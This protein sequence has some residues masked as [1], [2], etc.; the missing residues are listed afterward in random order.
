MKIALFFHLSGAVIWV[1]GMFFAYVC[2]RPAATGLL[3]PPQRLR[4]WTGVFSRFFPWVWLSV[5][6]ILISGLYLLYLVGAQYAPLY[7]YVM[8]A[9]GILMMLIFAHVYFAAFARLKRAAGSEDWPAGA[10]ALAQIRVLVGINLFLGALVV[11]TATLG[12][13]L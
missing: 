12:A 3:E 10:K 8:A 2:L 4:L 11:A 5:A 9:T 7:A 1:G 6:A 13:I